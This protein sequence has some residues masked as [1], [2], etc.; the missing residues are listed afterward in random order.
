MGEYLDCQ[1]DPRKRASVHLEF[2]H[3]M[4]LPPFD[5]EALCMARAMKILH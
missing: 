4:T 3:Y 1:R 2:F 5:K